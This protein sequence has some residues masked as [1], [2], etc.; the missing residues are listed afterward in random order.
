MN[1]TFELYCPEDV[2]FHEIAIGQPISLLNKLT[3]RST[4]SVIYFH[5]ILVS[6]EAKMSKT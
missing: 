6:L 1:L 2:G 5:S 4:R 3:E